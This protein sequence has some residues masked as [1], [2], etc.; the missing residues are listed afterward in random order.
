MIAEATEDL[1]DE[2]FIQLPSMRHAWILEN[3]NRNWLTLR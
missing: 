1:V 2:T 3:R